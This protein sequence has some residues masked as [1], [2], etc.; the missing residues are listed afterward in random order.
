MLFNEGSFYHI[1]NRGNNKQTIFFQEKNYAYFLDKVRKYIVPNANLLAWCLMPNHFHLLIQANEA[2]EK[3]V[4]ESPIPINGLTE[5]IR[6]LLSTYSQGVQKQQN[7]RGNLFQQKTKSKCADEYLTTVFH[8][9]HQNALKAGL[10]NRIEDYS[11]CS[12]REY[13]I[14][15]PDG[16]CNTSVAYQFMNLDTERFLEDSYAVISDDKLK[17]FELE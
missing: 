13:L 17:L 7:L 10:V 3:L 2:T 15:T 14:N 4:K 11:W 5:G 8:Y 6:L 9:I 1:Y 16:L 12:F